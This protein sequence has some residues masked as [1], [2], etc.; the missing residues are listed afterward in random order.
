[1]LNSLTSLRF[2]A[3][4]YVVLFHVIPW[5]AEPESGAA[6]AQAWARFCSHGF[7]SVGFFFALSGFILAYNYPPEKLANKRR[8]YLARFARVYPVY[9]VG[10]LLGLPFLAVRT[11][12]D[13][14]FG[15]AAAEITSA[16]TLTQAWVPQLWNAVNAPGW[17]L[18]VEAFFYLCF[19]LL[20]P[21]V[22]RQASTPRRAVIGLVVLYGVALAPALLG[23]WSSGMPITDESPLANFVRY[24]PALRLSEFTFGVCLGRW[25]ALRNTAPPSPRALLVTQAAALAVIAWALGSDAV[26]YMLLHNGLL[27]PAFAAVIISFTHRIG[28]ARALEAR[29]LVRLGEASYSL[30]ILHLLAWMYFKAVLER[31]GVEPYSGPALLAFTLLVIG[32]SLASHDLIEQPARRRILGQR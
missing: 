17:S 1:M 15:R 21:V 24:S 29:W 18:S 28:V 2:F 20:L 13:G 30:Y 5:G 22:A 27:L 23:T 7:V 11:L 8:F 3:A 14:A 19:P 31:V 4:F 16:L 32:A 10:L 26:P 25:H 12:R 9:A 6:L